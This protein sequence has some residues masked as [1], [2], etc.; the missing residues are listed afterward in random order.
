MPSNLVAKSNSARGNYDLQKYIIP[1]LNVQDGATLRKA[2]P[3]VPAGAKGTIQSYFEHN[4]KFYVWVY[5]KEWHQVPRSVV[6][7]HIEKD[8]TLNDRSSAD[9][10]RYEERITKMAHSVGI[11]DDISSAGCSAKPDLILNHFNGEKYIVELKKNRSAIAGQMVLHLNPATKTWFIPERSR[12]KFP[13]F[14]QAVQ[15]APCNGQTLLDALNEQYKTTGDFRIKSDVMDMDALL[16]FQTDKRTDI[17]HIE[18]TG[19]Y[20]ISDRMGELPLPQCTL[21]LRVRKK[22]HGTCTVVIDIKTIQKSNVHF[23]LLSIEGSNGVKHDYL[24]FPKQSPE[25]P[26]FIGEFA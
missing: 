25:K 3:Y 23:D 13:R 5:F 12:D 9:A 17:L 10:F 26:V 18:G 19:T 22:H 24:G 11:M 8:T 2:I 14:A 1:K 20:R 16:A 7:S 4:G 6:I 21:T 15:A